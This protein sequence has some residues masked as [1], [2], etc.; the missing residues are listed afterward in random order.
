MDSS[1]L[2]L[3]LPMLIIDSSCFDIDIFDADRGFLHVEVVV[4]NVDHGTTSCA[5]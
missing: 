5:G 4:V 1:S 2:R 3:L